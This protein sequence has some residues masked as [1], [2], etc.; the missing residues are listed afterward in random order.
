[1]NL[2]KKWKVKILYNDEKSTIFYINEDFIMNAVKILAKLDFGI[3]AKTITITEHSDKPMF[4]G[5]QSDILLG[6][7]PQRGEIVY[8]D[9][10]K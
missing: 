3:D 9:P 7:Q 4:M 6:S 10:Y 2:I 8:R 5:T 1:M